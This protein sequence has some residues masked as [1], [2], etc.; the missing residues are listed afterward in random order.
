MTAER[1]AVRCWTP[2]RIIAPKIACCASTVRVWYLVTVPRPI[3][4]NY[5]PWRDRQGHLVVAQCICSRIKVI[6]VLESQFFL[7]NT[8]DGSGDNIYELI[9]I[10]LTQKIH[11]GCD[12]DSEINSDADIDSSEESDWYRNIGTYNEQIN[13]SASSDE[14]GEQTELPKKPILTSAQAMDHIEEFIRFVERQ[15]RE[16][17]KS[18]HRLVHKVEEERVRNEHN[19][20]NIAKLNEKFKDEDKNSP[21]YQQKLK[22]LYSSVVTESTAEE[23]FLRSALSKIYEIRAIRNERRIQA[24]NAGNKETIRRGALMKML[25]SSAQ[26]LPLWI[27]KVNEKPPPLCGAIPAEPTYTAKVGDMVAALVKITEEEEN[28]ILA[29]VVQFNAATNK[30]EVDDIDEQKDRHILSRRLMALY[31]QTTC[32]YKAVVNQL[33][34]TS[35]EEYEVLFEDPTYADGYSPPLTVA[36]RY[37]IS[38]KD[39]KGKSQS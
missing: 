36:Q 23:E 5:T 17:L 6:G 9:K 8:L 21:Y 20:N 14:K 34:T 12:V 27:G 18:L 22:N 37:V 24:R 30:Y 31:P 38:I 35:V 25:L 1:Q 3:A 7:N 11:S 28:W 19:L 16:R 33:P 29:E 26:T 4:D 13:D 2:A 10:E 15:H 39:K 32:F